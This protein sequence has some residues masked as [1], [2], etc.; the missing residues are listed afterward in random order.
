[1]EL[2]VSDDGKKCE[3]REKCINIDIFDTSVDPFEVEEDSTNIFDIS[4]IFDINSN[5]LFLS[6]LP[7]TIILCWYYYKKRNPLPI[8]VGHAIIDFATVIQILI[9]SFSPGF[10]EM[11]CGM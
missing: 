5:D 6:F 11:M 2:Y 10:Y 1:M 8:M 9:T 4:C 7:L 3:R